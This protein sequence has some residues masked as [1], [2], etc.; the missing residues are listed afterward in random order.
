M[1]HPYSLAGRPHAL[2]T[3]GRLLRRGLG[4]LLGGPGF[5]RLR[6]LGLVLAD[7]RFQ[8]VVKGGKAEFLVG[9]LL[10]RLASGTRSTPLSTDCPGRRPRRTAAA[11]GSQC[12]LAGA[13]SRE[14]ESRV[15][16]SVVAG[17]KLPLTTP[18]ERFYAD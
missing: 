18:A 10:L 16:R 7:G 3:S 2:A 9:A 5:D 15:G 12:D 11:W 13:P 6:G 4:S 1:L 17:R 14:R 8:V